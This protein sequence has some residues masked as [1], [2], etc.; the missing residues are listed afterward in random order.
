MCHA[1]SAVFFQLFCAC[2]HRVG[3]AQSPEVFAELFE[4]LLQ[5]QTAAA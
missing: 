1:V 5:Q 3:G 2:R 4:E